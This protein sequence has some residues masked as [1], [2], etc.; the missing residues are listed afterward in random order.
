M[1]IEDKYIRELT[2]T[3]ASDIRATDMLAVDREGFTESQLIYLGDVAIGRQ[4][5]LDI[6]NWDFRATRHKIIEN[7]PPDLIFMEGI[8]VFDD[9]GEAHLGSSIFDLY[10]AG[11]LGHRLYRRDDFNQAGYYMQPVSFGIRAHTETVNSVKN[12]RL[13]HN[14]PSLLD[15]FV[16]TYSIFNANKYKLICGIGTYQARLVYGNNI[17]EFVVKPDFV[18]IDDNNYFFQKGTVVQEVSSNDNG[19]IVLTLSKKTIDTTG[20]SGFDTSFMIPNRCFTDSMKYAL[21]C[22]PT[23]FINGEGLGTFI[24][25]VGHLTKFANNSGKRATMIVTLPFKTV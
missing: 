8:T 17:G 20:G 19:D 11:E 12:L 13:M 7:I 3:P 4:Y 22:N 2:P 9:D 18:V 21:E 10:L 16:N 23:A 5:R 25:E 24:P 1:A 6:N 15:S 14:Y